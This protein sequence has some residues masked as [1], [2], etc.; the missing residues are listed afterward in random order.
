MKILLLAGLGPYLVNENYLD[1]TLFTNEENARLNRIVGRPI[2]LSNL[3]INSGG[4]NKN[5]LRPRSQLPMPNLSAYTLMHILSEKNFDYDYF[6]LEY[7]WSGKKEPNKFEYDVILL[8]TTFICDFYTLSNA[9]EWIT[10]RYPNV[11]LILGG[12][13]SNIKYS[14]IIER[15]LSVN[16]IIRGD[17]E[18]ALPKLLRALYSKHGLETVPNLIARRSG[19]TICKNI[20]VSYI[21]LDEFD[22]PSFNWRNPIAPYESMRG[23]P[24]KCKFCSFPAA[25][26]KWRYKSAEKIMS[27][28][29]LYKDKGVRLIKA[30][31]STFTV[32][33]DRFKKLLK[34]LPGIELNWEAFTRANII[35][36]ESVVE[37]LEKA[38]CKSLSI[39]FESMS[40]RSLTY[41]NKLVT[42]KQNYRAYELLSKSSIDYRISFMIGY[43][44]ETVEN[45]EETYQF[46]VNQYRGRFMLSIFSFTDETMPVWEDTQKYDLKIRDA[47]NPNYS[48]QHCGMNYETA[49]MLYERTTRDVRWKNDNGVLLL[50]QQRY[51]SPLAPSLSHEENIL[52]E[53]LIE[54]LS[55]LLK[56]YEDDLIVLEKFQE[57]SNRLK[58]LGVYF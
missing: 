26:P 10:L 40:D 15:F 42:A 38:H 43:P 44:G 34:N 28:W 36:D 45:Y 30:M 35:N 51:Q 46:L 54:R 32:P 23:C 57:I 8:S 4:K 1:D 29:L 7:V 27:D 6:D 24:F 16:Y 20:D 25:S 52:L 9:I 21:D 48:W 53:K 17:G 22:S 39:G 47:R 41:M 33:N 2:K 58:K 3:S 19:S 5:I 12:Q 11:T 50:W 31:D 13:F 18:V 56:D 14:E 49:Q 55:F 37:S